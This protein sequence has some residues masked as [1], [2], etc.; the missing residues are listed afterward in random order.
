[1]CMRPAAVGTP[2]EREFPFSARGARVNALATRPARN[3]NS[4]HALVSRPERFCVRCRDG[5]APYIRG[6]KNDARFEVRLST[7]TRRELRELAS[8]SGLTS[9]DLARLGIKRLLAR[10]GALLGPA[11]AIRSDAS[12]RVICAT[13]GG[14]GART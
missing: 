1:M 6:M 9:A 3:L 4:C 5:A 12:E 8:T 10:P 14:A 13:G 2:G 11:T 7:D